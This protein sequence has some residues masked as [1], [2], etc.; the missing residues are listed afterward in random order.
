MTSNRA[1]TAACPFCGTLSLVPDT[2]TVCS[3]A[4]CRAAFPRFELDPREL[5]DQAIEFRTPQECGKS[6]AFDSPPQYRLHFEPEEE[7]LTWKSSLPVGEKGDPEFGMHGRL[8]A[9][10]MPHPVRVTFEYR[11]AYQPLV[12]WHSSAGLA[13][14]LERGLLAPTGLVKP[15]VDEDSAAI[16][17]L[18]E[19][20]AGHLGA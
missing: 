18:P 17:P 3:C 15:H 9:E 4:R 19:G 10:T 7:W 16:I 11:R 1:S 13:L 8:G 20:I 2:G 5:L 6:V 14:P 12:S